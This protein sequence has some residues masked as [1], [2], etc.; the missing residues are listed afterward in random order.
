[1]ITYDPIIEEM[2]E[3]EGELL[4]MMW[5]PIGVVFDDVVHSRC[6]CSLSHRLA[7]QIE[8]ISFLASDHRI[9]NSSWNGILIIGLSAHLPLEE[10]PAIDSFGD[11]YET[12][13]D[14]DLIEDLIYCLLCLFNLIVEDVFDVSLTDSVPVNDYRLR[15]SFVGI[16]VTL[17]TSC[18]LSQNKLSEQIILKFSIHFKWAFIL[19]DSSS[20]FSWSL[21][22]EYHLVNV[23]FVLQTKAPTAF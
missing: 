12:Q 5:P 14:W 10:K 11:D 3:F 13:F 20:R 7:N 2:G 6:H 22:H 19:L 18:R 4:V 23:E 16:V 9:N 1:M 8:V 21:T 15:R 17:E